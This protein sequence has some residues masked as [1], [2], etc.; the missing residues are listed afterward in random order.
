MLKGRRILVA[1]DAR[2]MRMLVRTWLERLGAE[3]LEASNGAEALSKSRQGRLDCVFLDIN[4]PQMTGLSVLDQLRSSETTSDVPVIM[5]TTQ[6]RPEDLARGER[7][8]STAYLTKPLSYGA[9]LKVLK[10]VFEPADP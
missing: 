1:D 4:M 8:G 7:L 6:G 10:Y 3:V 9:L 2:V 5:L